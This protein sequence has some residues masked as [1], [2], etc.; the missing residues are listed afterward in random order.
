M[1][2][3]LLRKMIAV[4]PSERYTAERIC[5]HPYITGEEKCIIPLS[6]LESVKAFQNQE[7]FS[8]VIFIF[9]NKK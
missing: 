1:A 7:K 9:D 5:L 3:D 8:T 2:R 4:E 6:S